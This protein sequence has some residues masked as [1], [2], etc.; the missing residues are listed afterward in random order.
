MLNFT[1]INEMTFHAELAKKWWDHAS[2]A[3]RDLIWR[4]MQRG[5]M[6]PATSVM[7][8]FA[9]IGY[10]FVQQEMNH[11]NKSTNPPSDPSPH[12]QL[13]CDSSTPAQG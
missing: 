9:Q 3:D 11:G 7:A 13:A 5:H 8:R 2:D 4:E 6:H 1:H 12:H 10:L